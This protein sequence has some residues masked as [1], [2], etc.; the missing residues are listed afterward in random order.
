MPIILG[1]IA[2]CAGVGLFVAQVWAPAVAIIV[3][4]FS[5]LADFTWL[6]HYPIWALL[7]IAI[8]VFAIWAVNR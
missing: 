6:P 5:I 3:A 4:A 8:D 7:V 2:F 1:I